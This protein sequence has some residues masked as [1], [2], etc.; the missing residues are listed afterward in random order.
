MPRWARFLS[1]CVTGLLVSLTGFLVAVYWYEGTSAYLDSLIL[2]LGSPAFWYLAGLFAA[3][4]AGA[5]LA[6]RL[7]VRIYALPDSMAGLVAGA[8]LALAY[9]AVL[10][11]AQRDNWGGWAGLLH[12]GFPAAFVLAAPFAL[13]G[14][15][16][17]WLWGRLD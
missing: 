14:G 3:V 16:T 17:S 12:R 6:A 8:V 10:L 7:L 13:A 1:C 4:V 15:F 5:L 9:A 11:A 2:F